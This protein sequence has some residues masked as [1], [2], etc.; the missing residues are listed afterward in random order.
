MLWPDEEDRALEYVTGGG[1]VITLPTAVF[2][3]WNPTDKSTSLDLSNGNLTWSVNTSGERYV[4]S[5]ASRSSGKIYWEIHIDADSGFAQGS[6]IANA[7]FPLDGTFIGG[8]NSVGV[9]SD[10][11]IFGVSGGNVG[12]YASGDT[13]CFAIDIIANLFWVRT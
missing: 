7:S 13:L 3:T 8:G 12:A 4:R 5:T 9:Y 1:G 10:G 2:A 6:G 11:E